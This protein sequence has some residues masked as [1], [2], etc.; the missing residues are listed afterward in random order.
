MNDWENPAVF[1]INK[2]PAH[3]T[4]IPYPD[5][6]TAMETDG[7]ES[8]CLVSLNG[9]WK[10]NYAPKP[11]DRPRDF[12]QPGFDA[13]AWD[14]IQVPGNWETQGFGIPIYINIT[15]PFLKAGEK[16]DPPRL[17]KDNNPVGSYR[18]TFSITEA[19]K[20]RIV[21]LHFGAVRSAFYLWVN[22]Q[23]VG[24]SQDAKTPAEFD[25][26]AYLQEGENL[27]AVEVYRWS[28]GSYLEDQ[29]FWR[30]SGIDRDVFLY[31]V[32]KVYIRDFFARPELDAEYTNGN[33]TVDVEVRNKTGGPVEGYRVRMDLS[34]GIQ[35][36]RPLLIEE[37]SPA[38]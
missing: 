1:R 7:S 21:M 19:W 17:P 5:I 13:S 10:F 32:P 18:R 36:A 33:L 12:F 38:W 3:C 2:E 26:T 4:W 34:E 25:I 31:A 27:L 15:Y 14:S 24:Y 9:K 37:R 35:E 16:P 20:D 22:G 30:L 6:M 23:K 29:D 28:D 8:P 11:A